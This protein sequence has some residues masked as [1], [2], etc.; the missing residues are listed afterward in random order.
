M[1]MNTE[2]KGI[3]KLSVTMN[4]IFTCSAVHVSR[5]K[6]SYYKTEPD[7]TEQIMIT[8]KNSV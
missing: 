4:V 3:P 6:K 5:P 8:V 2:S 7:K 1:A